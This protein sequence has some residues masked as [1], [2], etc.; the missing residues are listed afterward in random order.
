MFNS[1]SG[2][3]V[4][5]GTVRML[6]SSTVAQDPNPADP[7]SGMPGLGLCGHNPS[8]IHVVPLAGVTRFRVPTPPSLR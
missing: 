8:H 2:P 1:F 5:L 7:A 6:A 3:L 4:P